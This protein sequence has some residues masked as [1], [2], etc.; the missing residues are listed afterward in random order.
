MEGVQVGVSKSRCLP[1]GLHVP[2]NVAAVLIADGWTPP[3][4]KE[5]ET[6]A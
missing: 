4:I 5:N 6:A 1:P 2:A 3:V